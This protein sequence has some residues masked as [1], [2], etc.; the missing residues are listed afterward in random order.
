MTGQ[1]A[2]L[3]P[4]G[5]VPATGFGTGAFPGAQQF[6]AY[7]QPFALS[8]FG[9]MTSQVGGYGTSLPQQAL[10]QIVHALQIVP[11]QLQQLLQLAQIQHQQVQ[12]LL[13]AIPQQL[14]QL[15]QQ[16][17]TQAGFQSVVPQ[18]S[19]GAGFQQIPT[20]IPQPFGPQ[21]GQIM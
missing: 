4:W 20:G 6:H 2:Q 14:Q 1:F 16:L 5:S 7:A 21:A 3:N 19:I 9:G 18:Q 17:S 11:Q 13:Q 12:Y 15:Q 8:P 10:P